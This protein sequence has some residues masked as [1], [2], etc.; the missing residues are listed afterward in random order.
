[1]AT[2]TYEF[3]I[4]VGNHTLSDYLTVQVRFFETNIGLTRT[5]R[6]VHSFQSTFNVFAN[7]FAPDDLCSYG[8][9]LMDF[10][11]GK[12]KLEEGLAD[13]FGTY[14][15]Y[16]TSVLGPLMGTEL[17]LGQHKLMAVAFSR[18]DVGA[19]IPAVG[20][21]ARTHYILHSRGAPVDSVVW[22]EDAL[23]ETGA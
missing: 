15:V 5:V 20:Q 4:L 13:A 16:L 2:K 23:P 21:V 18:D 14:A 11:Q 17:W 12:V 3:A 22:E 7:A 10:E 19:T 6:K 9:L 1:M 8:A